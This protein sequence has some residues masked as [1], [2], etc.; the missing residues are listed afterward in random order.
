MG[1]QLLRMVE[2]CAQDQRERA[3]SMVV[4][5][6]LILAARLHV[7]YSGR[8]G[9]EELIAILREMIACERGKILPQ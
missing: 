3:A 5:N 4:A 1:E 9:D 8:M 6:C 2:D 7:G